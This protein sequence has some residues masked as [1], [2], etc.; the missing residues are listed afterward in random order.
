MA[1]LLILIIPCFILQQM[2]TKAKEEQ[3]KVLI[4]NLPPKDILVFCQ[5]DSN[6][7]NPV[8]LTICA[9]Y[10]PWLAWLLNVII[11][12]TC[13]FQRIN[14]TICS[15][16]QEYSDTCI[17]LA[18]NVGLT[19]SFCTG[20]TD[21]FYNEI[22]ST[23]VDDVYSNV[24][25]GFAIVPVVLGTVL[26][27]ACC[28]PVLLGQFEQG[29]NVLWTLSAIAFALNAICTALTLLELNTSLCHDEKV[30]DLALE[31]DGDFMKI[32]LPEDLSWGCEQDCNAGPGA[33]MAIGV[34]VLW[35][36]ACPAA[37]S[38]K[39]LYKA[40]KQVSQVSKGKA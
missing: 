17:Y 10:V 18:L 12:G 2:M 34:T 20:D 22:P 3:Q 23:D 5:A 4:S 25:V 7:K 36:I 29:R 21:Y 33:G 11:L 26:I 6:D 16:L 28:G 38:L 35:L 40:S 37:I 14:L 27:C 1:C 13:Y 30:C 39:K 24:A 8:F 9:H 19:R 15:T 32:D 31:V